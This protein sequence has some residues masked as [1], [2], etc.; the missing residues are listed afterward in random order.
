M[1]NFFD[2]TKE[3]I[4]DIIPSVGKR[5]LFMP[6]FNNAIKIKNT[7]FSEVISKIINNYNK[8]YYFIILD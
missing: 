8:K 1:E 5:L 4:K 6:L 7:N 2:L 3:L